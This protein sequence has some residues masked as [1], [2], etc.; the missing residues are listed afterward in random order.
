MSERI[1]SRASASKLCQTSGKGAYGM[2]SKGH[3]RHHDGVE[4]THEGARGRVSNGLASHR[5][6]SY[7]HDK[8]TERAEG[9]PRP[10][11]HLPLT[12]RELENHIRSGTGL[13]PPH[14]HRD[15]AN[16]VAIPTLDWPHTKDEAAGLLR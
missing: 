14:L 2:V 8:G 7:L 13:A 3:T 11:Q 15:W 12:A 9:D 16:R 1:A 10:I 6:D 4:G 5:R